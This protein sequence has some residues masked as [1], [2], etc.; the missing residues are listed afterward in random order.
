MPYLFR[1]R[2][3]FPRFSLS[4]PPLLPLVLLDPTLH[5]CTMVDSANAAYED[6]F[7]AEEEDHMHINHTEP[8]PLLGND[9]L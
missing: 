7:A 3:S 6:F 1:H 9:D 8:E 2:V 4:A 5:P